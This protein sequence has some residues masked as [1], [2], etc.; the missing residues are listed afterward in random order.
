MTLTSVNVKERNQQC[1]VYRFQCD[2]CDTDYVGY[3]RVHLH[4]REQQSS[5]I[6]KHYKNVQGTMPQGLLQRFEV[7][8]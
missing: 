4:N 6:A 7:F 2:L 5:A 1:V 8:A 3:K